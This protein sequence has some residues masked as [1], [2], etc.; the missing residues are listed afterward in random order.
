CDS[1]SGE[2]SDHGNEVIVLTYSSSGCKR[3]WS[4][5]EQVHTKKRNRLLHDRMRDH[6][7]VKFNSKL[8]N[9][10]QI[11][12]KDP[13]EKEVDDVGDDNEFIT[14]LAAL[15]IEPDEQCPPAAGAPQV[16]STSQAAGHAKRKRLVRPRKKKLRSLQ[17]LMGEEPAPSSSDS[18]GDGDILMHCSDNSSSGSDSDE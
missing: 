5:F 16:E 6:V 10:K 1:A 11:K 15:S 17:S 4:V 8:R 2:E 13:L 9:K 14:G 3:N 7:F 18:E 12:D